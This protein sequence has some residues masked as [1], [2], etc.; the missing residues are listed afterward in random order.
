MAPCETFGISVTITSVTRRESERTS[1]EAEI[2]ELAS[3]LETGV[4]AE[5]RFDDAEYG[6]EKEAGRLEGILKI[7]SSGSFP[8]SGNRD[9]LYKG[10][11]RQLRDAMILETHVRAGRG[12]LVT[13]DQRAFFRHPKRAMLEAYC[14]TR[15]MLVPEFVSYLDEHYPREAV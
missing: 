2:A 5:S 12:V 10:E 4:F 15:I 9:A 14:N 11:Q 13:N 3:I 7:L 6:G 8:K 1:F